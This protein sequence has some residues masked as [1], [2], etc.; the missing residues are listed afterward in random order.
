MKTNKKGVGIKAC[1]SQDLRNRIEKNM[2]QFESKYGFGKTS[3]FLTIAL[4]KL[5]ES[6]ENEQRETMLV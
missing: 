6:I 2:N 3:A 1:I 4:T 5:C